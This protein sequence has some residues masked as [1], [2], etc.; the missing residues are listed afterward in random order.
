MVMQVGKWFSSWESAIVAQLLVLEWGTFSIGRDWVPF[1]Y[2]EDGFYKK[3][4][5]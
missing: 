3:F 2:L 4:V 1:V 5:L